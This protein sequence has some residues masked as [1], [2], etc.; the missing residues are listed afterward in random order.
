MIEV[1][2]LAGAVTQVAGGISSAIK[3]GRDIGDLMPHMARLG[4]LDSE[5]Q[6]AEAGRHKGPLGR[7]SSPEQE[8][9]AIAQAKMAHSKAMDDLR[10]TFQ[11]YGPPGSWAMVQKEMSAARLR[12]KEALEEQARQRDALFWGLSVTAGVF[13]FIVGLVFMVLGLEKAVNG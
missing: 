2:A 1:L 12:H 6:A 7:L 8:G 5:I 11:L 3:A 9:L 10:E 4:K 13:V